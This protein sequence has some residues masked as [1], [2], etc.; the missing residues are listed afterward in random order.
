[1]TNG[2]LSKIEI[3]EKFDIEYFYQWLYLT[4]VKELN[5][6]RMRIAEWEKIKS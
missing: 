3:I 5:E 6:L 4:R 2:D 1:L